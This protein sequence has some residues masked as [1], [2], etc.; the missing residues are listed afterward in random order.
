MPRKS[1]KTIESE[2]QAVPV[3][4]AQEIPEEKETSPVSANE[5][6]VDFLSTV[7]S[8]AISNAV[9]QYQQKVQKDLDEKDKAIASLQKKIEKIN[10]ALADKQAEMTALAEE[11]EKKLEEANKVIAE[12]QTEMIALSETS[13]KALEE[14]NKALADKQAEMTALAEE[15]EK[16]LEEANKA[17]ADKQTEMIALAEASEMHIKNI[18]DSQMAESL[19]PAK[20]LLK[21]MSE[22]LKNAK[23][24]VKE[25][26]PDFQTTDFESLCKEYEDTL[27]LLEGEIISGE[28]VF[29]HVQDKKTKKE[30]RKRIV[31]SRN[32]HAWK[33]EDD[34]PG[35]IINIIEMVNNLTYECYNAKIPI[36]IC[37][38]Y[39]KNGKEEIIKTIVS[40]EAIEYKP[41]DPRLIYDIMC[42]LSGNFTTVPKQS[43]EEEIDPFAIE[44]E[45]EEE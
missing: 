3:T 24:Y 36:V 17:I 6:K 10:K 18:K 38:Q 22:F 30:D 14:A 12:K 19:L 20:E 2:I 27:N 35:N 33:V 9:N 44:S 31:Y 43:K 26:Q 41:E 13:E 15:S 39:K 40:P 7:L 23:C 5:N 11:S 4:E 32:D 29:S 42:V 1:K 28:I 25:K 16:K 34:V 37:S 21:M 45:L 8:D